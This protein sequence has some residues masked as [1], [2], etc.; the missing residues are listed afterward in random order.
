VSKGQIRGNPMAHSM[1]IEGRYL[2]AN[3]KSFGAKT[4]EEVLEGAKKKGQALA[5][6]PFIAEMR[7][8]LM[9]DQKG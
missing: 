7:R 4:G 9:Q 8:K 5:E 3:C 1:S 2:G 6:N